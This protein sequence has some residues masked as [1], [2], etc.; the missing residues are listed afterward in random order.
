MKIMKIDWYVKHMNIIDTTYI[1]MYIYIYTMHC[2]ILNNASTTVLVSFWENIL[3]RRVVPSSVSPGLAIRIQVWVLDGK[4]LQQFLHATRFAFPLDMRRTLK[5]IPVH[6]SGLRMRK[7]YQRLPSPLRE[8]VAVHILLVCPNPGNAYNKT[9][10]MVQLTWFSTSAFECWEGFRIEDNCD[11]RPSKYIKHCQS[12]PGIGGSSYASCVSKSWKCKGSIHVLCKIGAYKRIPRAM[13]VTVITTN[14]KRI[15]CEF[16]LVGKKRHHTSHNL[17]EKPVTSPLYLQDIHRRRNRMLRGRVVYSEERIG[18]EL[19]KIS[20]PCLSSEW[21]GFG[22][23]SSCTSSLSKSSLCNKKRTKCFSPPVLPNWLGIECKGACYQPNTLTTFSPLHELWAAVHV[24]LVCPNP[25]KRKHIW[26]VWAH[27][28]QQVAWNVGEDWS[29]L[30]LATIQILQPRS[31]LSTNCGQ[32]FMYFLCVQ[33]LEMQ[34][35]WIGLLEVLCAPSMDTLQLCPS[36]PGTEGGNNW[37]TS[38][39]STSWMPSKTDSFDIEQCKS[40]RRRNGQWILCMVSY[41]NSGDV[42][43]GSCDFVHPRAL[44]S[45]FSP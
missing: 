23:N 24:L 5:F 43:T 27:P 41:K 9:Q 4:R 26:N 34:E 40:Q 12:S 20:C 21:S 7:K 45:P 32:Q 8:L 6:V 37:F 2:N 19:S 16:G 39:A 33:I 14:K 28:F 11:L 17:D 25:G 18:W 3:P 1:N 36:S 35:K 15:R 13:K 30:L 31:V 22:R 38:R 42:C 29:C 10:K 44:E